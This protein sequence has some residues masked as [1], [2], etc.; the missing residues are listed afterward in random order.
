MDIQN[1]ELL[2]HD[3]IDP[4]YERRSVDFK[5]AMPWDKDTMFDL[6]KDILA[7]ANQGG[8]FIVVGY[9]EG[10]T[11]IE[12]KRQGVTEA[13]K[14]TWRSTEVVK[15]VGNYATPPIDVD[16]IIAPDSREKKDYIILKI[17]SH[18]STPHIC[19]KDRHGPKDK[20]VLRGGAI[21]MRTV[22][23]ACEEIRSASDMHELIGRCIRNRKE[24]IRE[25]FED[26][27]S[28]EAFVSV[29]PALDY[30]VILD[31]FAMKSFELSKEN[32]LRLNEELKY[33][34]ITCVPTALLDVDHEQMIEGVS[35]ATV[36]HS[37]GL[38]FVF[39]KPNDGRRVTMRDN[40][41]IYSLFDG[42]DYL[43]KFFRFWRI[44]TSGCFYEVLERTESAMN[45]GDIYAPSIQVQALAEAFEALGL[46]YDS[47]TSSASIELAIDIRYHQAKNLR[48]GYFDIYN[49]AR[50]TGNGF[51]GPLLYYKTRL[52]LTELVK[53]PV[54]CAV[55]AVV[56]TIQKLGS[57]LH[58]SKENLE[59]EGRQYLKRRF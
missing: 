49:R 26:V 29:E 25:L 18:G 54:T 52:S 2:L 8:G 39:Y 47:L 23:N 33:W 36:D 57:N 21:Y 46:I 13:D 17:P 37:G 10:G 22:N 45:H 32:G 12:E 30:R 38:E 4:D 50:E 15:V 58:Y 16:V 34:D 1:P 53:D 41:E 40:D 28:G 14:A 44:N 7:F 24:E 56:G 3:L 6:I 9:D 55:K 43:H 11:T 35:R 51:G 27:M 42:K 31:D 19:R 48:V 5:R 20:F 59:A